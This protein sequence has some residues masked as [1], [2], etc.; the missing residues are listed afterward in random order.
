MLLCCLL[1]WKG[2]THVIQH[3]KLIRPPTLLIANTKEQ[4]TSCQR[5]DQLLQEQ[6][7]QHPTNHREVEVMNLEQ[8]I[9]L[10]RFPIAHQLPPAKDNRIVRQQRRRRLR[11]RAHRCAAGLEAPVLSRVALDQGEGI[12]EYR[13]EGHAEGTIDGGSAVDEPGRGLRGDHDCGVL[14]LLVVVS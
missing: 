4:S 10:E 13:P 12:A 7:Q 3:N 2:S 14:L 5:R 9:Q 6:R 8:P 11:E 1:R